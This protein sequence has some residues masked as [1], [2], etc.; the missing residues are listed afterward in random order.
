MSRAATHNSGQPIHRARTHADFI[1]EELGD[2][3]EW[4]DVAGVGWREERHRLLMRLE[5]WGIV[6][7]EQRAIG[8]DV[9]GVPETLRD[10]AQECVESRDA[11]CPCGHPGIQNVG[12][13]YCCSYRFCSERFSREEVEK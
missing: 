13:A 1:A 9:W 7:H 6:E 8:P 5:R 11:M 12:G 2:E 3:F 4:G 10:V